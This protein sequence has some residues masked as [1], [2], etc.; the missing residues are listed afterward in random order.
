VSAA[1]TGLVFDVQR[2]SLHNGPGIRTTVFLKGCPARCLWCHNPE[3]QA[4]SPEVVRIESRCASCGTCTTVCP[5]GAPPPGSSLCTACG[6]CVEACPACARQ[7]AG[8]E[9]TVAEVM[10]E[11]LRDRVFYEESGGGVT[12]SGGE[13]L[14][15][16]PF[17]TALL[18]DCRVEELHTVVDTCGFASQEALLRLVP[19][20][21]LFLFDVKLLDD[22]RHREWTGL[23]VGPILDNLRALVS[24][25]ARVRA[26]IP[27]VPG[28]TDAEG[29]LRASAALLASLPGLEG[30]DL[31][32]F[33]RTGAAKAHR[34]GREYPLES[35]QP[36]PPERLELLAGLFRERGLAVTIGGEA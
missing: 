26:R 6:A 32:P 21:D 24:A 1:A 4:F 23:P 31:I 12:F 9:M 35:L 29:D 20:V 36:P 28:H 34:L 8:R 16:L 3:S 33:H 25:G 7:M 18:E 30:V 2:Y 27:L 19:L 5:H 17:L 10:S 14:A 13:P 15:Q 22:A 11:V